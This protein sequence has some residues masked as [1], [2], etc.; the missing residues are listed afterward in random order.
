MTI[1]FVEHKKLVRV[2]R[3]IQQLLLGA[4][5]LAL[6]TLVCFRFQVNSTTVALLYLIVIG[7]VSL[8]G[9]FVPSAIVSMIA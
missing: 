9:S 2:W 5:G 6:V 4:V 7:L 8:Q 3:A 1:R